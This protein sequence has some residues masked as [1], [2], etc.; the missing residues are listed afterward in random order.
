[1]E[2]LKFAGLGELEAAV[3]AAFFAADKMGLAADSE[4]ETHKNRFIARPLPTLPALKLP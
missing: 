4:K 3:W 1:M 2:E